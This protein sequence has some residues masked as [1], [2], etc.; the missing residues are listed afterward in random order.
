MKRFALAILLLS[1]RLNADAETTE[2]FQYAT[3]KRFAVLVPKTKSSLIDKLKEVPDPFHHFHAFMKETLAFDKKEL[4]LLFQ[5]RHGK[6][7]FF[8]DPNPPLKYLFFL[9]NKSELVPGLYFTIP[10]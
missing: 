1:L 5:T 7:K 8:V 6:V 9:S 2:T 3:P 10:L 4:G